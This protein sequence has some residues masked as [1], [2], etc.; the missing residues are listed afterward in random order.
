MLLSNTTLPEINKPN[1]KTPDLS[2]SIIDSALG[3]DLVPETINTKQSKKERKSS[4]N[5]IRV[6]SDHEEAKQ[7]LRD[8]EQLKRH[9]EEE[10]IKIAYDKQLNQIEEQL[11]SFYKTEKSYLNNQAKQVN[12]QK[13]TIKNQNRIKQQQQDIIPTTHLKSINQEIYEEELRWILSELHMQATEP[14][15]TE[16]RSKE[17]EYELQL[18]E[19][20]DKIESLRGQRKYTKRDNLNEQDWHLDIKEDLHTLHQE[21]LQTKNNN[22]NKQKSQNKLLNN[23]KQRFTKDQRKD[24]EQEAV[25]LVSKFADIIEADHPIPEDD[26]TTIKKQLLDVHK[27]IWQK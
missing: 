26:L 19:I 16:I 9:W 3:A 5:P 13:R 14:Q 11:E 24:L 21:A 4:P 22:T 25:N 2:N 27:Q 8:A 10:D 1:K 18:E 12:K 15:E 6:S 7:A 23:L 20:E 17:E